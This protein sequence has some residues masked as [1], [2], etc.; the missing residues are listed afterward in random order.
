MVK[1]TQYCIVGNLLCY[2][3]R[4]QKVIWVTKLKEKGEASIAVNCFQI[5]QASAMR[6]TAQSDALKIGSLVD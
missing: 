5:E 2:R 1:D 3:Y 4:T 6:T